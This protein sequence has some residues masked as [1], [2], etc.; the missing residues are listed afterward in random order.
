MG[1]RFSRA[2]SYAAFN[3]F[4]GRSHPGTDSRLAKEKKL[5]Y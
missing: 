3:F 4:F 2:V 5:K 1:K